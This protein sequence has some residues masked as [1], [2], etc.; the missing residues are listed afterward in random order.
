[1][2][3]RAVKKD[4][5]LPF[6]FMNMA[7]TAD[8]KI[9]SMNGSV[10]SFGSPRDQ[11]HLYELR[12]QAD[13]VLCGART[14]E[15]EGAT[16]GPGGPTFQRRRLQNGLA[17]FNLRV[18]VSGSGSINPST[19]IFKA[20]FSPIIILASGRISPT[21]LRRLSRVADEV[22]IIGESEIDFREAFAWLRAKWSVKRLL[23]E[24][25]GTVNDA[26]FR[27]GLVDQIHL[28]ICPK[29]FGGRRAPTIA[30]GPGFDRLNLAKQ[31]QL[32]SATQINSELFTVFS[33]R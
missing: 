5:E 21:R 32:D 20:R 8:G 2:K 15:K 9:A 16:L 26:L 27:T 3:S 1:M 23:C 4:T 33:K 12:A 7:M 28:T 18:V 11:A 6:V 31:F 24:G 19:D 22:K 10:S 17:E 14:V 30:D 25:G 13:A 29:I